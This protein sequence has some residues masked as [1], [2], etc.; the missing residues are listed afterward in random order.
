MQDASTKVDKYEMVLGL[1]ELASKGMTVEVVKEIS[2]L[3][4]DFFTHNPVL[5]FQLKQ[6]HVSSCCIQFNDH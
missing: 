4:P 1:K 5:L 6:V 3:D 2:A